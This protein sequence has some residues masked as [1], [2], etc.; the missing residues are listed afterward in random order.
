MSN[1][2]I[3]ERVLN[4]NLLKQVLNQIENEAEREKTLNAINGMLDE[5]QGKADS[6][7]KSYQDI[8]TPKNPDDK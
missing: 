3:K 6:L 1:S 5:F 4:N 2:N 7:V 8:K